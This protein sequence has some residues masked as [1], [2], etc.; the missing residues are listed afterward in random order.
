M[1]GRL[2]LSS[3]PSQKIKMALDIPA[4]QP[5]LGDEGQVREN[6]PC[7]YFAGKLAIRGS[8]SACAGPRSKI[9]S[10]HVDRSWFYSS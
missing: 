3:F 10:I 5:H 7:T 2:E 9:K 6:N 1:Q 4:L 8:S